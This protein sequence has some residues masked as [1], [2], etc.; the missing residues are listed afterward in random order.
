MYMYTYMYMYMYIYISEMTSLLNS[1]I[2]T[3]THTHMATEA[4]YALSAVVYCVCFS[5]VWRSN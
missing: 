3:H 1:D 4:T 2:C 5:S